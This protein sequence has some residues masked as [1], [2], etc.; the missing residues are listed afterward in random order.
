VDGKLED[1]PDN[2]GDQDN[3]DNSGDQVTVVDDS[4]LS[5]RNDCDLNDGDVKCRRSSNEFAALSLSQTAFQGTDHVT[6]LSMLIGWSCM[7]IG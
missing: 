2:P 4:R 7:L 6:N 1:N 3:P 5:S